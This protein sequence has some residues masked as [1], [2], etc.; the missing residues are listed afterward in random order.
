MDGLYGSFHVVP[1]S[2]DDEEEEEEEGEEEDEDCQERLVIKN[3]F[4]VHTLIIVWL[5]VS[6]P[7][8]NSNCRH[9]LYLTATVA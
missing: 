7:P 4:K 5:G 8:P 3:E 1:V 2:D 9:V 6:E